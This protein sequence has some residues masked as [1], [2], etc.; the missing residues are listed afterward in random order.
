MEKE[1]DFYFSDTHF[2]HDKEWFYKGIR[3]FS[4][5]EEM[6]ET[7]IQNFNN[8]SSKNSKILCVGDFS[9]TSEENT[10]KIFSRLKGK[11]DLVDGNHDRYKNNMNFLKELF[12]NVKKQHQLFIENE[13]IN[14]HHYPYVSKDLESLAKLHPNILKSPKNS[15]PCHSDNISDDEFQEVRK[16]KDLQNLFLINNHDK[17]FTSKKGKEIRNYLLALIRQ[18]ISPRLLD[19][20]KILLCGHTH[21]FAKINLNMINLCVE[22]WDFNLASNEEI[23]ECIK[24]IKESFYND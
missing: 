12:M 15:F 21:S 24:K 9:I 13:F 6:N 5:C 22:A 17:N 2:G 20:N 23:K 3:G 10:K 1:Y 7:I 18:R 16:N 11:F 8:K 19:D 4:S 14:V